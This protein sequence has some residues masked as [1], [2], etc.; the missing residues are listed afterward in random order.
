MNF[1]HYTFKD[2]TPRVPHFEINALIGKEWVGHY[3]RRG[4][5][6]ENVFVREDMRRRGICKK[7]MMHAISQKKQLRLFVRNNN[8][9]AQ[10]SYKSV[11]F[12]PRAVVDDMTEMV[13]GL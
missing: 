4:E 1:V 3:Q 12:V 5:W 11:G 7:M 9:E 2:S 13:V 8:L 10:H 6:I